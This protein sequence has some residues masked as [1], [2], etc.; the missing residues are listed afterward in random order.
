MEETHHQYARV[1]QMVKRVQVNRSRMPQPNAA[2]TRAQD[3]T[4]YALVLCQL[5]SSE[6][7]I[8]CNCCTYF[9]QSGWHTLTLHLGPALAWE[10]CSHWSREKEVHAKECLDKV[11][12]LG[13]E[14]G[15]SDKVWAS[16]FVYILNCKIIVYT[17]SK[18]MNNNATANNTH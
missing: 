15:S 6:Y 4:D 8:L 10:A 14:I 12:L 7:K 3:F 5:W 16:Y 1:L 17:D 2:C 11:D 18:L 13:N 9:D